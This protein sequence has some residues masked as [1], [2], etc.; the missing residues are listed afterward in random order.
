MISVRLACFRYR[1]QIFLSAAT[2]A[3]VDMSKVENNLEQILLAEAKI[4]TFGIACKCICLRARACD[5]VPGESSVCHQAE[6]HKVS[7]HLKTKSWNPDQP[8]QLQGCSLTW[9]A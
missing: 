6:S 1:T 7:K 4:R 2:T 9:L 5:T 8:S 3:I